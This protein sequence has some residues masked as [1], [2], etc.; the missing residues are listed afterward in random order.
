MTHRT[1][2]VNSPRESKSLNQLEGPG[3]ILSAS[4]MATGGRILHHLVQRLPDPKS[5]V[6]FVG[7]QTPGTRGGRIL[8]GDPEVKIHGQFVRVEAQV[9]RISGFSAHAGK[10][11]LERWMD[12]F[13][14][15]PRQV[16]LVHGEPAALEAHRAALAARGWPAYVP[17]LNETVQLAAAP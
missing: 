16:L 13:K 3:I 4:G 15:A 12:G 6:L 2:F 5:T 11:E 8:A 14:M 1:R 10:D 7:Y 17:H 9:R